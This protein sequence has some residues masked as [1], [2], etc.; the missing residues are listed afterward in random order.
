V[1][2]A[3]ADAAQVEV[4]GA[5]EHPAPLLDA[6][7]R[8]G[9]SYADAVAALVDRLGAR[10][11]LPARKP[12]PSASAVK[13]ETP[14]APA[15]RADTPTASTAR[16]DLV[17]FAP[18]TQPVVVPPPSAP[19]SI[20]VVPTAE[21]DLFA[22]WDEQARSGYES[23]ALSM[24]V[25]VGI[26][27]PVWGR[28]LAATSIAGGVTALAGLGILI[29]GPTDDGRYLS[30]PSSAVVAPS[31]TFREIPT[32]ER[33]AQVTE[34]SMAI[35]PSRAT[36]RPL[37]TEPPRAIERPL[38]TEP[39]RVAERPPVPTRPAANPSAGTARAAAP[40]RPPAN[41][42]AGSAR[43]ATVTSARP[44]TARPTTSQAARSAAVNEQPRDTS[45]VAGAVATETSTPEPPAALATSSFAAPTILPLRSMPARAAVEG[46]PVTPAVSS[47]SL[48][49]SVGRVHAGTPSA[50]RASGAV[51]PPAASRFDVA[52]EV[53]NAARIQ[54]VLERAYPVSLRTWGVGGR[55]EMWFYVNRQGAVD[56]LQLKRTTGNR[57]LDQAALRVAESFQFTPGRRG[58]EPAEGWV[59]LEIVFSGS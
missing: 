19:G 14:T 12:V 41:A 55:A 3:P 28:G 4:S 43:V 5:V 39:P 45:A 35:E 6:D 7:G 13:A 33:A 37:V 42:S 32:I 49:E 52:P 8:L 59:A 53:R 24:P 57:Q 11:D 29:K 40:T 27:W 17:D 15:V 36:E 22:D 56:S 48:S 34:P 10:T 26:G 50:E 58:N 23:Q 18:A 25:G 21:P 46:V 9:D 51:P 2:I 30:D 54:A 47:F 44:S 38:M 31:V 20:S 16:T 1:S